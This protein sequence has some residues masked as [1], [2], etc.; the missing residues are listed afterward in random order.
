LILTGG[1]VLVTATGI[2]GVGGAVATEWRRGEAPTVP[3]PRRTAAVP[4]MNS[5]RDNDRSFFTFVKV[6][7][8]ANRL[9]SV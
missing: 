8:Y 3:V 2:L 1:G 4:R 5:P 6:S 7:L 9:D